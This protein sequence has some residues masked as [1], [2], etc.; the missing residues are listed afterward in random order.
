VQEHTALLEILETDD[1]ELVVSRAWSRVIEAVN[2]IL[3]AHSAFGFSRIEAKLNPTIHDVLHSL[4]IVDFALTDFLESNLLEHNEVRLALNSK[5]CVLHLRRVAAALA[6]NNQNEYDAAIA[7]LK[8][9][10]Q[11]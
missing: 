1:L 4:S 5:Q 2:R 8:A 7:D 9:Q 10:P 3:E 6:G 11:I